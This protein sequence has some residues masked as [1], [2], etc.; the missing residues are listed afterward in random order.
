MHGL[1]QSIINIRN[2]TIMV[3]CKATS[4]WQVT[5][6]YRFGNKINRNRDP[7]DYRKI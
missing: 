7:R 6:R 5:E 2:N 3:G 1:V 4:T